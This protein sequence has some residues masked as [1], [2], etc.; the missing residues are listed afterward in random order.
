MGRQ[1]GRSLREVEVGYR[2]D[3]CN[4]NVEVGSGSGKW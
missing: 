4:W 2:S 3:E 1:S